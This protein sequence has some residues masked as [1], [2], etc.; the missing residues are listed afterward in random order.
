M[1]QS[2]PSS[3]KAFQF[4]SVWTF[5]VLVSIIGCSPFGLCFLLGFLSANAW[6]SLSF[7]SFSF[8]NTVMGLV[9]Y[10]GFGVWWEENN[11]SLGS[12]LAKGSRQLEASLGVCSAAIWDPPPIGSGFFSRARQP[13]PSSLP[14][15]CIWL[16]TVLYSRQRD[17]L[18]LKI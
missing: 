10:Q 9:S 5:V 13:P 18:F 16:L 1:R 15:M 17:P 2:Q 3:V 14:S 12:G 7:S 8:L 4:L 6:G 11:L